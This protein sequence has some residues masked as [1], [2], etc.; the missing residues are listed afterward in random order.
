M[1]EAVVKDGRVQLRGVNGAAFSVTEDEAQE[2]LAGGEFRLETPEEFEARAISRERSTAGQM[3]ITSARNIAR[4]VTFGASEAIA[5]ELGG[6]EYRQMAREQDAENPTIA[7]ASEIG[8]AIIPALLSGGSG[9][10]GTAARLTP[11]GLAARAGHAAER[12]AAAFAR[13]FGL[14]AADAGLASRVASEAIKLGAAGAVEGAAYGL[15]SSLADSALEGTEWTAERALAGLEHGF[16]HGGLGGAAVG[17][18]GAVIGKAGRAV[19]DRMIGEGKTFR[20][21]VQEFADKR[22]FKAVVGNDVQTLRKITKNGDD[23][24]AI[25][26][27]ADKLRARNIVGGTDDDMLRGIEGWADEATA[28]LAN[29]ATD[30][31]NAGLTPSAERLFAQVDEQVKRL[32]EVGTSDHARVANRVEAQVKRL[33]EASSLKITR[34]DG[35]EGVVLKDPTFT[36]LRKFKTGLGEAT[37]WHKA[38]QSMATGEMQKLYGSV[39]KTLDEAADAAGGEAAAMWRSANEDAFDALTLKKGL[40]TEM[41]AKLK[42]RFIS[43]SDY[44]TGLTGALASMV[45]GAGAPQA[46]LAGIATSVA[47]KFVRERGSAAIGKLADWVAGIETRMGRSAS[48]LAGSKEA[49]AAGNVVRKTGLERLKALGERGRIPAAESRDARERV[50]NRERLGRKVLRGSLPLLVDGDREERF[51][52]AVEMIRSV[53]RDPT[54]ML[55]RVERSISPFAAQQPEVAAAM[56]RRVVA[57]YQYLESKLPQGETS[58]GRTIGPQAPPVISRADQKKF[59]SYAEALA[60]PVGVFEDAAAGKIDFD[61][62]D[63]VRDRRPELFESMRVRV[64]MAVGAAEKPLPHGQRVFLS[65]AFG[66]PFDSSMVAEPVTEEPMQPG[67]PIRRPSALDEQAPAEEMAT[68]AQEAAA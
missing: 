34:A 52:A 47:H 63:A 5:S 12:G 11:A 26:R 19:L 20:Q 64:A 41:R 16:I 51:G 23:M 28:K 30:L 65:V 59:L 58:F 32:R 27:V 40:E 57:D 15:G 61:A 43:P 54:Q 42:N 50:Q 33:R 48:R 14:G 17:A 56:A 7:V 13:R 18:G 29:V 1:M 2:A 37:Q 38:S 39:A 55:A 35:S 4:G 3:A 22:T 53:Q 60:D 46:V 66:L 9:A 31:D 67:A 62:L 6:D 68:P 10:V 8:G 44:G 24:G 25:E 21:A 36:A 49:V 45:V